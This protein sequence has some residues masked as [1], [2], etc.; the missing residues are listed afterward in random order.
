MPTKVTQY[1]CDICGA[2]FDSEKAALHCEAGPVLGDDFR[3][4]DELVK[5]RG[6]VFRIVDRHIRRMAKTNGDCYHMAFYAIDGPY[7]W[8]GKPRLTSAKYIRRLGLVS[9]ASTRSP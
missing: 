2:L 4:G 1:H 9:R 6:D 7:G 5:G 3:L 8:Q